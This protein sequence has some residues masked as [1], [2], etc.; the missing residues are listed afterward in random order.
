M[1][2]F[3]RDILSDENRTTTVS[4]LQNCLTNLIDLALQGKQAHW[5]V[6]GKNFRTV[7]LQLDEIIDSTR[8][9]SD[10][11]AERIVTLGVPADGRADVVAKA[12]CLTAFPDGMHRA[13][14]TV[15]LIS[16][17]LATTVESL[18]SGIE[19]T[20]ATDPVTEDLL[21]GI[22]A[23]LEKHLWMLQAQEQ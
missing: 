8:A 16:D 3:K 4:A 19:K 14:E 10:D 13:D 7:H 9:A 22:S 15:T 18:R 1:T 20:G 17:R 12:S 2:A 11:V 6:M 5:N 21:I 23:V